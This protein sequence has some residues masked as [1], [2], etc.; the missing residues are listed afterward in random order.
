MQLSNMLK[1]LSVA[2][3]LIALAS[4]PLITLAQ[5]ACN[6][7][8]DHNACEHPGAGCDAG[9]GPNTG[10]CTY[11]N[12]RECDCREVHQPPPRYSLT[13]TPL[14]PGSV[15]I[16]TLANSIVTI[17]PE[18]GYIGR[19]TLSCPGITGG[20]PGPGC[21]FSTNPVV[22]TSPDSITSP[23]TVETTHSATGTY[24]IPVTGKDAN[25]LLGIHNLT[26]TITPK[27]S[28]SISVAPPVLT[29]NQCKTANATL[30]FTPTDIYTG[31]IKPSVSI[32]SGP[33]PAPNFFFGVSPTINSAAPATTTLTVDAQHAAP[34]T[35]VVVVSGR[36]L[37]G[38]APSNGP[39]KFT[40]KVGGG[41]TALGTFAGLLWLWLLVGMRRRERVVLS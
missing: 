29:V 1:K 23:L 30:T 6:L 11:F 27:P 19:V 24:K 5:D 9:A 15:P 22:I 18:N 25:G 20:N 38:D 17:T 40:L 7:T 35:Y 13:A 21:K 12:D 32:N 3:T 14:V 33:S 41:T 8:P 4:S 2:L 34:G 37:N 28:Y 16:G 10:V 31:S 36:D 39:Q 26:L